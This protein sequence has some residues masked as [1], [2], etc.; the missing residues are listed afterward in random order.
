MQ[1]LD[2]E[3]LQPLVGKM[4]N[5]T[6]SG[7]AGDSPRVTKDTYEAHKAR[8]VAKLKIANESRQEE[9]ERDLWA[10]ERRMG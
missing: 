9:L 7:I 10:I 4:T 2:T 3:N 1:P 6:S 8:V 5:I